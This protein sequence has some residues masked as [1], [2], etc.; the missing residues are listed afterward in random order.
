MYR[1]DRIS[2]TGGGVFVAV[3]DKFLSERLED[4]KSDTAEILWI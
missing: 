4:L 1:K 2:S 3:F